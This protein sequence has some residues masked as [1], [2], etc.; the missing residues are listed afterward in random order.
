MRWRDVELL[1]WASWIAL[2]AAV[3]WILLGIAEPPAGSHV[4][5]QTH[6]LGNVQKLVE[7]GVFAWP[8]A[9]N[10]DLPGRLYDFPVFAWSAAGIVAITGFGPLVVAKLLGVACLVVSFVA[11]GLLLN[12]LG[13]RPAV[14]HGAR[15]MFVTAPIVVFYAGT[16]LPDGL[17]LALALLAVLAHARLT[18]G[19]SRR[20]AWSAVLL[21]TAP[22]AAAIK[23]PVFLPAGFAMV[24]LAL[25][26]RGVRG[27]CDPVAVVA[28]VATV[29]AVLIW[30]DVSSEVNA[31]WTG[32]SVDAVRTADAQWYFGR[33]EQRWDPV[34]WGRI[35]RTV[36]KY[37]LDPIG[38]VFAVIGLVALRRSAAAA[39]L[40]GLA[41]GSALGVVVFFNL[42]WWHDYY[43][44]SAAPALAWLAAHGAW[45]AIRERLPG[46]RVPLVFTAVVLLASA[47]FSIRYVVRLAAPDPGAETWL[48]AAAFVRAATAPDD[49]VVWVVGPHD[50]PPQHLTFAGR[51]GW[52]A[53]PGELNPATFAEIA[54]RRALRHDAGR[55]VLFV[56]AGSAGAV[57]VGAVTASDGPIATGAA[58]TLWR[59]D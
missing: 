19:A 16:A 36:T 2:G 50:H 47:G 41:L 39:C 24:A 51:E 46:R 7:D 45:G 27:L 44:L 53:A 35:L 20:V 58:G 42:C 55:R 52:M 32:R 4:W 34:S 15:W 33:L 1:R 23:A 18:S 43:L 17:A 49:Y 10:D 6:A 31:A 13:A 38:V 5:R 54:R 28:G 48:T 26:R 30:S 22:L 9:W 29:A 56:P 21:L 25:A 37:L 3:G 59:L 57:D 14:V 12:T 40:A 8:R 11:L